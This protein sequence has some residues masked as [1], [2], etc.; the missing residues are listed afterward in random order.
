MIYSNPAYL[1]YLVWW[2]LFVNFSLYLCDVKKAEKIVIGRLAQRAKEQKKCR[3]LSH[4]KTHPLASKY[5]L[6][7]NFATYLLALC[8][9]LPRKQLRNT[10]SILIQ[11][12]TVKEKKTGIDIGYYT[13]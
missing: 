9:F 13:K 10:K 8:L 3:S 11:R 12:W 4:Y 7:T 5:S 1:V 2:Y 6:L